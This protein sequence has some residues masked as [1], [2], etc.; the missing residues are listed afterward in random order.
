MT[1]TTK[2]S[3]VSQYRNLATEA[4]DAASLIELDLGPSG[5]ERIVLERVPGTTPPRP[6]C[7]NQLL[8]VPMA[9]TVRQ[10]IPVQRAP[11][12]T[13][14][15]ASAV[16]A[17]R[18]AP[19]PGA[20]GTFA[21]MSTDG[22]VV[23]AQVRD[24]AAKEHE[25]AKGLGLAKGDLDEGLFFQAGTK[26]WDIGEENLRAYAAQYQALPTLAEAS[27]QHAA[28]LKAEDRKDNTITLSTWRVDAEGKLR[29][30]EKQADG[31]VVY[32]KPA[33][34]ISSQAMSQIQGYYPYDRA[35]AR[36]RAA[37]KSV[38]AQAKAEEARQK[39]PSDKP[40]P[41][42]PTNVNGWLGALVDAKG[43]PTQHRLRARTHRGQREI[44]GVF[45]SSKRGYQ[46]YDTDRMLAEAAKLQPGLRVDMKY[47]ADTTR[48]TARCIAQ[49]PIDIPA[50]VGVGRVHQIG[51]DLRSADDG[52]MSL[53]VQPF[54]IRVRCKNASLVHTEGRRTAFRHV[55]SFKSL[56]DGL[57][58]ALEQAAKGVDE[59]RSLWARAAAEHFLDSETGAQLSVQET[60]SR[61]I[62]GEYIPTAG[63]SD[64]EALDRYMSAW[65]AEES[66]HSAMGI[67][68]AMQRAAHESTWETKWAQEEIEESASNLLYQNVYTLDAVTEES[69]E[70]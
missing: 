33:I 21:P 42:A 23:S 64:A 41:A 49:A 45:S 36:G 58:T 9:P 25:V 27:E 6:A 44:F 66:P 13:A 43:K 2:S 31:T 8:D 10:P 65:R 1:T 39:W 56:E 60:F 34:A 32:G 59:M 12:V 29:A 53:Q 16:P 57:R 67:I 30:V 46:T 26:L 18:S 17:P 63:Q 15:V 52:S 22:I 70:A 4:D 54:L 40:L 19:R 24:L 11:M 61:L 28:T 20:V 3:N 37:N 38:A 7:T 50:F 14:A 51:F 55:G 69:A 68:M 35:L 5:G 48:M 62:A 47:D